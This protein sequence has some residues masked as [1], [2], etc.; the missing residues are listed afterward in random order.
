MNTKRQST[1]DLIVKGYLWVNLPV[2]VIILTVWFGL[3]TTFN[4]NYFVCIFLGTL[5]G[6]YF[7]AYSIK[8]WIKWAFTNNI[9]KNKILKVG[10]L[11]LLLWNKSTIDN[12][13]TDETSKIFKP[14]IYTIIT[15]VIIIGCIAI[16]KGPY[17]IVVK[18]Y[19]FNGY[20]KNKSKD[21]QGAVDNYSKALSY[22][23]SNIAVRISRGS[24]YLDLK[25]YDEAITDYTEVIRLAPNDPRA[26]AYRGRAYY[27]LVDTAKSIEDY[28]KAISL[29]NTFGYAFMNRGL[30]K[31][32]LLTDQSGG[33]ADLK[34]ALDLGMTEAQELLDNGHCE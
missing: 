20:T 29:D 23:K 16:F 2:A 6:W 22:D 7:W 13:F 31:Y 15:F 11:S 21:F 8:K 32:T 4:V 25:K 3:W 10:R 18:Y 24:S 30:L 12:A 28:N 33:C 17:F 26:Y 1:L 5:A 19:D 27:E 14:T 9:D 34:K